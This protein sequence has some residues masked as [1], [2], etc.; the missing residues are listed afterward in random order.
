LNDDIE[1]LRYGIKKKP[2]LDDVDRIHLMEST[3]KNG[4]LIYQSLG[5]VFLDR[6][7]NNL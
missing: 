4:R 6:S 1:D 7:I 5:T 3:R 2:F